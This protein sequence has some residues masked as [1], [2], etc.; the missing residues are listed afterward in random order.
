MRRC[1]RRSARPTAERDKLP[2][3]IAGIGAGDGGKDA[4]IAAL[5]G[6][7]DS[8]K[9]IMSS[10]AAA[11]VALLNQ[12]LAALRTQIGALEE[13]LE[14]SENARPRARPRS[15]ISGAG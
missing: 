6:D 4:Q 12:Q 7:L 1:R 5:S 15:P 8:Q 13:A 9:Q 11:Q 2:A 3:Q 10:E 14:C